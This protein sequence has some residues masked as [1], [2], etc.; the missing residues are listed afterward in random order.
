MNSARF[1][2]TAGGA[3]NVSQILDHFDA[4]IRYAV[5]YGSGAVSQK[6]Y[7]NKQAGKVIL[8]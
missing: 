7:E 4:P 8:A 1:L 3:V 5:A 2:T 6:G